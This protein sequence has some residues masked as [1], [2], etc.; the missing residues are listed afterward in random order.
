M[1]AVSKTLTFQVV[2]I[3]GHIKRVLLIPGKLVSS[4][5]KL[6]LKLPRDWPFRESYLEAEARLG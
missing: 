6:I 4:G 1:V 2:Q 3:S 5:R